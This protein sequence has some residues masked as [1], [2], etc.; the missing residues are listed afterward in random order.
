M[1]WRLAGWLAVLT[2][3]C[4]GSTSARSD[5]G[6]GTGASAGEPATGGTTATGGTG[7]TLPPPQVDCVVAVHADQCCSAAI[8][9]PA[10]ALQADP[11]LVP[12]GLQ[13]TQAVAT[14]CPAAEQCLMLN[15]IFPPPP[16]RMAAADAGGSCQFVDECT[17]PA[18]CTLAEN[19]TYCCPCPEVFPSGLAE[20]NPCI[21]GGG[22]GF[23]CNNCG[24]VM[25][26]ACLLPNPV[27][28]CT[29]GTSGYRA[30]TDGGS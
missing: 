5:G 18:D 17:S 12:Y 29:V 3:A 23:A 25:C 15:C 7:G 24:D 1:G 28:T 11:C 19:L 22:A 6:G 10:S 9:A 13:F 27:P 4:G 14:V 20:A 21:S 30:C 8:A 26:E 2:V 16:T